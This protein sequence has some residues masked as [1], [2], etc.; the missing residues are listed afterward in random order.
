MT[1]RAGT[2]R[3]DRWSAMGAHFSWS[4]AGQDTTSV[5]VFHVELGAPGAPVLALVHGFP[6]CS[7]DW[8]EVGERVSARF[9]VCA[10]DFPRY[11]FSSKRGGWRCGLRLGEEL[12]VLS[13]AEVVGAGSVVM[14]GH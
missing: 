1:H 14:V 6:T 11:G 13:L 7:V 2:S 4:P 12:L 10:L 5:Q 9:R 8:L 3:A